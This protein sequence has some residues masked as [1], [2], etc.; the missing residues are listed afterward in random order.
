MTSRTTQACESVWLDYAAAG[1]KAVL[2]NISG[3]ALAGDYLWSASDEGRTLECLE[4]NGTGFRLHKQ[5]KLDAL[6]ADVP[7]A[8][9]AKPAEADIE[10]LAFDDGALWVCGSHSRV[11]RQLS[12]SKTHLSPKLRGRPS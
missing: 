8:K 10:S 1:S 6:F 5:Y 11:R 4:L 3:I 7:G 12:K 9:A 2:N